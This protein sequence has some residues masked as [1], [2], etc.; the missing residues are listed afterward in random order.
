MQTE[1]DSTV[2]SEAPSS[3]SEDSDC[4][5]PSDPTTIIDEEWA[6]ELLQTTGEANVTEV[7]T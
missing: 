1:P 3:D 7:R 2:A 5:P 4:E 6:K